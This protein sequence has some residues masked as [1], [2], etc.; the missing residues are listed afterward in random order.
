[1]KHCQLFFCLLQLLPI[2]CFLWKIVVFQDGLCRLLARPFHHSLDAEV[3]NIE[4]SETNINGRIDSMVSGLS[5]CCPISSFKVRL[6]QRWWTKRIVGRER[7]RKG[8]SGRNWLIPSARIAKTPCCT[9]TIGLG[10]PTCR[11]ASSQLQWRAT[12]CD[13]VI[14]PL[15][16]RKL[17]GG[18][19]LK[20]SPIG[21]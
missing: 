16:F 7:E 5:S 4:G 21:I 11:Q 14:S 18:I 1:M 9:W 17:K 19:M 20:W 3:V 6:D 15:W 12:T 13:S 8:D 2:R 10:G